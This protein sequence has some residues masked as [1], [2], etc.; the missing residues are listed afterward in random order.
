M[1]DC[2]LTKDGSDASL[3]VLV[4]KDRDSRPTLARPVLRKGRLRDDAVDQAAASIRR[5]GH[6]QRVLLKTDNE[7]ALVDLRRV[8]AVRLGV[9]IVLESPPACEPQANGAIENAVRQLKGLIRTLML[10]LQEQIQG[11]IPADHP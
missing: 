9:Q 2:F 10:A 5:L 11:E 7:P 3:A 6:H 8:V 1:D 4:I